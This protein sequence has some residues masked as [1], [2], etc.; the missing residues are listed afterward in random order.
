MVIYSLSIT[1]VCE[2]VNSAVEV[3]A[4]EVTEEFIPELNSVIPPT[5][6]VVVFKTEDVESVALRNGV[7]V[8]TTPS[9]TRRSR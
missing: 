7:A 6:A 4:K 3:T 5:F 8:A 2:D 9:D 1:I